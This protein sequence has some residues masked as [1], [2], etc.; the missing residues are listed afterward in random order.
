MS[1]LDLSNPQTWL[2]WLL[3][4]LCGFMCAVTAYAMI[5]GAW[6]WLLKKAAA[7]KPAKPASYV[8]SL[9]LSYS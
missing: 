3:L 1:L 9:R 7:V 4:L 8:W 6:S 2:C 5:R